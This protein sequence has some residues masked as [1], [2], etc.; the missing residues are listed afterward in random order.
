MMLG[1][2]V[3]IAISVA[4]LIGYRAKKELDKIIQQDKQDEVVELKVFD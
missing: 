4:F 2:E 3:I 1:A